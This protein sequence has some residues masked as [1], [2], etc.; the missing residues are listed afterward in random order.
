MGEK[1]NSALRFTL[2]PDLVLS[3]G[4]VDR[5]Y[6]I[7]RSKTFLHDEYTWIIEKSL[8]IHVGIGWEKYTRFNKFSINRGI[9]LFLGYKD[10]TYLRERYIG[11]SGNGNGEKEFF[12]RLIRKNAG[13]G[14]HLG[15][16]YHLSKRIS[17]FVESQLSVSYYDYP[18]FYSGEY[19]VATGEVISTTFEEHVH[20]RISVLL[21]PF[22]FI[23]I[24]YSF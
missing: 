10:I 22:Y 19:N 20:Q 18:A 14:V 9:N 13:V 1:R 6:S 7:G 12:E 15:G 21:S 17:L 3:S 4:Y 5:P 24:S 8:N 16:R 11:G 2:N 23:G